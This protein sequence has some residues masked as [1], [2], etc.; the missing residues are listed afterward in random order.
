MNLKK[1]C[2]EKGI[3]IKQ[4]SEKSGI[5]LVYLYELDRG[6]KSPSLKIAKKIANVLQIDI[7]VLA[8]SA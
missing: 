5:S 1:L 6:E 2:K 4:L 7:N 8:E 3:T